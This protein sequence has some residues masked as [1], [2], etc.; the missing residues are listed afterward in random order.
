MPVS[1]IESKLLHR[2]LKLAPDESERAEDDDD[3]GATSLAS[4]GKG[5]VRGIESPTLAQA[6]K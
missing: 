2:Q 5:K 6:G 3:L 4:L 1:V